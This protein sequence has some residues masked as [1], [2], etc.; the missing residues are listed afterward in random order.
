MAA[1]FDEKN[2][3]DFDGTTT[4]TESEPPTPTQGISRTWSSGS[5]PRLSEFMGLW[6]E[7]AIFR[8]FGALSAQN[9][10]FLQAEIAHLER[11]LQVVREREEKQEDERG[12][13]AQRSWYQLSQATADGEHS[14]QWAIIQEIRAKLSEYNAFLLQYQKLCALH[15]PSKHDVECLREWL[16]RP[17]C[18][19]NFLQGVE[20]D[21]LHP[22]DERYLENQRASDL[23][24]LSREAVERDFFSQWISDEL[25]GRFHKLIGHR[26]KKP[27]D[28]ESGL[29]HYRK[30][31]VRAISH[32]VGILLASLIP[33]ASIFTLYFVPHMTD[34]LGVILAYSA[35]FSIC[36]GLFTTA[37][38]V[39]IFA[40][41]AA[42]ASVQ[43]VFVGSTTSP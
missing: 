28:A 26:F 23:V 31:N 17:E 38:R 20:R 35:L 42:F 13:L 5:Y 43:V 11:E 30:G 29:Y 27:F 12:L 2:L 8:R 18:G 39:E 24:T 7:V 34:R 15:G 9:L 32:L 22:R 21:I 37:R 10:L 25:L 33:A 4:V 6:P 16:T 36:L 1:P 41:T 40:A 3:A 14:P 19:D